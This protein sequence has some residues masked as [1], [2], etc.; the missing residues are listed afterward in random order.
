MYNVEEI[1]KDFPMLNGIKMHGHPLIYLDNG[2]TTLKPKV[3]ADE[4]YRYLTT[5]S[6]NAHRGDYDLSHQ[7]DEAYSQAR[8]DIATFI[9]AARDEEIVFT[10]GSTDA[11]NLVAYGYGA[12]HLKAGDEVLLSVAEH[13][14]NTLPW[15]DVANMTGAVIKYIDLDEK[16]RITMDN[17]KKAV[18]EHT[19]IIS[20]A[21][22]T[23]VLGYHIPL[24]EIC[25]YAHER[26]IIVIGDGA[27][28]VPHNVTDVQGDDVDFLAMSAHKM[29]GPTG[30]GALYGKYHLLEEMKPTRYGG[31]SNARYNKDGEVSLKNPPT[32]FESGTQN[33]EGVI[34]FGAAVRYLM[35]IGMQNIHD[36]EL[37]LRR[38][39]I[40]KLLALDNVTV[41]NPESTGAITFNIKGVFAQDAA[42]LFNTYGIAVR[43]GEHCAKILD[44]YLGIKATLRVSLYLY[45]TKEEIDQFIEVCKK[46]DDWLDAFFG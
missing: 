9:N 16:G 18:N 14:S 26:G 8:H 37:E 6:G 33:I 30:I 35:N 25:A 27:Q 11:L 10:S 39:A 5:Y 4:V 3:V 22:V 29:L 21:V 2:A 17:V 44:N 12:T 42:S 40:D 38:Y 24:R 36:H 34:G 41:Y 46:G 1:R 23:N 31:D 7:V 43:A 45:N 32:K 19:K 20:L 15:F 13:A 28:S